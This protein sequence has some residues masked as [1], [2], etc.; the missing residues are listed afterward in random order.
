[1]F[2]LFIWYSCQRL[3]SLIVRPPL[4]GW[5]R[6]S[7]APAAV[8]CLASVHCDGAQSVGG[9]GAEHTWCGGLLMVRAAWTRSSHHDHQDKWHPRWRHRGGH[10]GDKQYTVWAVCCL[11]WIGQLLKV[12]KEITILFY[13]ADLTSYSQPLICY[14]SKLSRFRLEISLYLMVYGAS[15]DPFLLIV[16]FCTF[17]KSISG[18]HNVEKIWLL[19][20]IDRNY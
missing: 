5:W 16:H 3:W 7:P 2:I 17:H 10:Q 14:T 1:M 8:R 12:N 19:K 9:R 13:P 6:Q 18:Q 20:I 11:P 15:L 4:E